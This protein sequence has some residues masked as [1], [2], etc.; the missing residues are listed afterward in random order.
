MFHLTARVAWHDSRWNGKVCLAPSEN[1]FCAALDRVREERDDEAEDAVAGR[2]WSELRL[3]E[4]PACKVESG[5]FMSPNEW[6]RVFVHPYADNKKTTATHGHHR[7]TF[8]K[9]PPFSAFAVP[10]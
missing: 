3:E 2:A 9:V 10:F 7:P 5:A 1:S 4:L 6:T 8:V